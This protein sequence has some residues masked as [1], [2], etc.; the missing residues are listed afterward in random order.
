MC[1]FSDIASNMERGVANS[2]SL[3]GANSKTHYG[4]TN[5]PSSKSADV[6]AQDLIEQMISAKA[7]DRPSTACVL[8]HPF[9]WSPEKQLL[10]FQVC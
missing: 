1:T 3:N 5:S 6:I 7:E 9:F 10:F 2:E 4:L 8:K